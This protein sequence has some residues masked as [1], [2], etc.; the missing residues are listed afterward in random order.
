[1]D[2]FVGGKLH[3]GL[4]KL[5]KK[6]QF[7][8]REEGRVETKTGRRRRGGGNIKHSSSPNQCFVVEEG[9]EGRSKLTRFVNGG[10]FGEK[11]PNRR[12]AA[13]GAAL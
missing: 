9:G 10:N 1:M 7:E 8:G 4:V 12:R 13:G 6:D 5:N 3:G 2:R 11:R